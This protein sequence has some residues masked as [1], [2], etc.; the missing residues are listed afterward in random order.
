MGGQAEHARAS[1][2]LLASELFI[3]AFVGVGSDVDFEKVAKT[4][5]S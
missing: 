4:L 3:L 1:K 2:R 5:V